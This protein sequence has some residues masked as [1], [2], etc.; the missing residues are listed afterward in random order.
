MKI[1]SQGLYHNPTVYDA[2]LRQVNK[3]IAA[4]EDERARLKSKI[5]QLQ[6]TASQ[7]RKNDFEEAER[8][9]QL[10]YRLEHQ[11]NLGPGTLISISAPRG[12]FDQLAS[13]LES[14]AIHPDNLYHY[15]IYGT[16]VPKSFANGD[17]LLIST[18]EMMP[19]SHILIYF[20]ADISGR[21]RI[22]YAINNDIGP[23]KPYKLPPMLLAYEGPRSRIEM[24]YGLTL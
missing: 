2:E 5:Y 7:L 20:Y 23:N 4:I 10:V 12:Y 11:E 9:H 22:S 13:A 1:V 18:K 16:T 8:L 21:Q 3:Q 6:E 17:L 14:G 24:K 15:L 19:L